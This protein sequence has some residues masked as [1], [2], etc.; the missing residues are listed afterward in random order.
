MGDTARA[1]TPELCTEEGAGGEQWGGRGLKRGG[2]G[3]FCAPF[4]GGCSGQAEC[5]WHSPSWLGEPSAGSSP[6]SSPFC[7]QLVSLC[8]KQALVIIAKKP[9]LLCLSPYFLQVWTWDEGEVGLGRKGLPIPTAHS[10][11][12]QRLTCGPPVLACLLPWSRASPSAQDQLSE[13]GSWTISLQGCCVPVAG[14]GLCRSFWQNLLPLEM[15]L[16]GGE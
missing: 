10:T 2:K 13:L 14:E 11:E 6:A 12:S 1:F 7:F 9:N 16:R 15:G 5:T 4:P 8:L 3:W